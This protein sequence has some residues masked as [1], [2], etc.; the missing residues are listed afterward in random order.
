[1][2]MITLT[3]I[4]GDAISFYSGY[5]IKQFKEIQTISLEQ[6]A[7]LAVLNL[8]ND[9]AKWNILTCKPVHGFDEPE[10]LFADLEIKNITLIAMK[11]E[12]WKLNF[13]D[14][15]F[16]LIQKDLKQKFKGELWMTLSNIF[17]NGIKDQRLSKTNY[18]LAH[19]Y[20][21]INCFLWDP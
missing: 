6:N 15:R 18:K 21:V 19:F 7:T 8:G 11:E 16:A 14:K 9:R 13:S 2:Q 1:M 4:F 3:F 5:P 20:R 17:E 10:E 12:D